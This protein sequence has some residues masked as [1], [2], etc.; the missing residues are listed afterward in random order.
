MK[1][2]ARILLGLILVL[3][4]GGM[5][6]AAYAQQP[7]YARVYYYMGSCSNQFCQDQ[8][9]LTT[10]DPCA[11]D[12]SGGCFWYLTNTYNCCGLNGTYYTAEA[13]PCYMALLK[14]KNAQSDLLALA[15]KEQILVP[16]CNGAYLPLQFVRERLLAVN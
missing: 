11:P 9:P 16:S 13:G 10:T 5:G 1:T 7:C 2:I 8:Y 6:A 14:D 4:I 3:Q 15:R 12:G